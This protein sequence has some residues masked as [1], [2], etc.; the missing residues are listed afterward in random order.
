LPG[1]IEGVAPYLPPDSKFNCAACE[2]E[3]KAETR[4]F[5]WIPADQKAG[6]RSIPGAK[7]QKGRD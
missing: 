1:K 7:K 2:Y 3:R 4:D 6:V 5:T